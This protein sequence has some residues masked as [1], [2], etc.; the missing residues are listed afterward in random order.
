MIKKVVI[1]EDQPFTPEK[2]AKEIKQ[3]FPEITFEFHFIKKPI[4]DGEEDEATLANL[5]SQLPRD[6]D[7][8]ISDFQAG[9]VVD[10]P[11]T[12]AELIRKN[13]QARVI[14]NSNN[15]NPELEKI[16]SERLRIKDYKLDGVNHLSKTGDG[17]MKEVSRCLN[18]KQ[19]NP[20]LER[21]R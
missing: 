10:F 19:V 5:T 1:I 15:Y 7:L 11:Y 13:P 6:V 12:T 9:E 17:L 4:V 8:I 14:G 21:M 16:I 2:I 20:E 18:L 3:N